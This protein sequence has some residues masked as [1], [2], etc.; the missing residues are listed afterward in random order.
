MPTQG[1]YCAAGINGDG[2]IITKYAETL[3]ELTRIAQKFESQNLNVFITPGTFEEYR[4]TSANSVYMRSLFVDLD[5]RDFST[6]KEEDQHKYYP[7]KD[8][9]LVE[10][11][12]FVTSKNLPPPVYVDSGTGIHAYWVFDR[13]IP[14]EE[15]KPTAEAF[16]SVCRET[17]KIDPTVTADAARL[18]RAVGS[19]NQKPTPPT[20]VKLLGED[21]PVHSFDAFVNLICQ[22][23]VDPVV[24]KSPSLDA[25]FSSV[26]KGL[27][28]DTL[29]LLKMDNFQY[30]FKTIAEKSLAG[31]GCEQIKN[32]LVNSSTLGYEMWTAGLSI[33][34]KCTDWEESV[35][36]MSQDHP[37]YDRE[38]TIQKAKSF[39]GFHSCSWFRAEN[40]KLCENCPHAARIKS[41]L[42]LGRE[43]I[44]EEPEAVEEDAVRP[45]PNT[46][47]VFELPEYLSGFERG[48]NGGIYYTPP[49]KPD[50]K[51]KPI[52]QDPVLIFQ[53]DVFPVKRMYSIFD[54]ECLIVR[55]ILPKD[56][57]REFILPMSSIYKKDEFTK[58]AVGNGVV[59]PSHAVEY[60]MKYFERWSMYLVNS[61]EAEIM[62]TQMGWTEDHDAFI[63]GLWEIR[64][65]CTTVPTAAS[66]YVKKLAKLIKQE[67]D[68]DIWKNS[69]NKLNTPGLEIL[70]VGLLNGFGSPL[71][72]FMDV[73]GVSVCLTGGP[74]CGKTGALYS[75]LSLFMNPKEGTIMEHTENAL[76]GRYLALH[77][78]N[79]GLDEVSNLKGEAVSKLVHRVSSGTAKIRMQGSVN[80][81]REVEQSAALILTMT[82]NQNLYD[83]LGQYKGLPEGEVARLIEFNLQK[84]KPFVDDPNLGP[85]IFIPIQSNYGWAGPE[86]IKALYKLGNTKILEITNKWVNKFRSQFGHDTAYRFYDA[87]IGAIFGG[88]EIAVEHGIIDF[89]LDRIYKKTVEEVIHSKGKSIQLNNIDYK[90]LFSEFI[91]NNHAGMLIL[92]GSKLVSEPRN[93]TP[94]VARV[95]IDTGVTYVHKS[96]LKRFLAEKQ[97]S[98]REFEY[99][100]EKDGFMFSDRV[101]LSTGWKAGMHTP[102]VRVYG[103]KAIPEDIKAIPEDIIDE[104]RSTGT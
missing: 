19:K 87:W 27:D 14:T 13:D 78:L 60:C 32:I 49:P 59:F 29:K 56:P 20:A 96:A 51:G 54:G 99:N 53:H 97:V 70:S 76:I 80:A 91:I 40:P 75:G 17:L 104:Y 28:E 89:D 18:M 26:K 63:C 94:L 41:P 55:L 98:A 44:K 73:K 16:K 34:S 83:K 81:E 31:E 38:K 35:I 24:D 88:G 95:N 65:D 22:E 79:F 42:H 62:R 21:I 52:P 3:D 66:P 23:L 71:M 33:A 6:I 82:S 10:L 30:S 85:E 64:K 84:P 61:N 36:L 47:N 58:I 43:L 12:A 15:W 101:R 37:G 74:G 67:G 5:V 39:S 46:K 100:L 50:K 25:I 11:Q 102:P 45:P 90:E 103:F 48:V 2:K 57:E 93:S 8:V 9:A 68:Y 86:F 1:V 92:N 77:S 72:R 69:I 7:G 4:R